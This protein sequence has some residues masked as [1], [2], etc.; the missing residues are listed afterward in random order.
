MPR[1]AAFLRAINVGG[2]RITNDRLAAAVEAVGFTDVTTFLASGNVIYDAGDHDPAAATVLLEEGMAAHLGFASEAFVRTAEDLDRILEATPFAEEALAAAVTKPQIMFLRG[3]LDAATRDAV[4]AV[5]TDADHLA[6][7]GSELHW[8][9][10]Q[11]VGR[12]DLDWRRLDPLLGVTTVR[13]INT[14]RRIRP[15]LG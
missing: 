4:H 5:A 13:N 12:A 2:R 6:V 8:L 11:G 9:P 15:K 7:I 10:M 3:P 14:V 1:H